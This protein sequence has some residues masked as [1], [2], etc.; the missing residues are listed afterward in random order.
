MITRMVHDG[1]FRFDSDGGIRLLGSRCEECSHLQFP[2]AETCSMCGS[3][4]STTIDLERQGT[5]WLSTVVTNAP[6][7]YLGEVPY[8]FGVVELPSGLRI[9]TLITE[10]EVVEFGTPL[11]LV[12]HDLGVND[13]GEMVVTYAFSPGSS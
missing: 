11:R 10:K 13:D 2:V 3:E 7:G 9:I 6:P 4:R 1:L 12:A 5:L 8:G